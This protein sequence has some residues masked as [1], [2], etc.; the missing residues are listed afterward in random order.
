MSQQAVIQQLFAAATQQFDLGHVSQAKQL[1]IQLLDQDAG[2]APTLC[3]HGM[4]ARK[5]GHSPLAVELI[6][7]ALEKEPANP[8]YWNHLGLAMQ[9]LGYMQEAIQLYRQ[10]LAFDAHHLELLTQLAKALCITGRV[11]EATACFQQAILAVRDNPGLLVNYGN[12]LMSQGQ[13]EEAV[14]QYWQAVQIDPSFGLAH[15]NLGS[16]AYQLRDYAQARVHFESA[17]RVNPADEQAYF[18]LAYAYKNAGQPLEEFAVYQRWAS[19]RPDSVLAHL[20]LGI[21]HEN[22]QD[23]VGAAAHFIRLGQLQPELMLWSVRLASLSPP[24]AIRTEDINRNRQQLCQILA[25]DIPLKSGFDLQM[26]FDSRC[27]PPSNLAYHGCDDQPLKSQFADWLVASLGIEVRKQSAQPVVNRKIKIGFLVTENHERV[28]KRVLGGYLQH[29]NWERFALEIIC[30]ISR[31]TGIKAL[32]PELEDMSYLGLPT[33]IVQ[34]VSTLHQA[35]LDVLFF[36]EVGTDV[37]NY[38][39]SLYRFAPVQ[40]TSWGYPTTSGSPNMDYYISSAL[41]EPENAQ[42]HYREKLL[43]MDSLP[44]YFESPKLPTVFKT[45]AELGLSDEMRLYVCPQT[46]LKFHPDFDEI[47]AGILVQDPLGWIILPEGLY[48]IWTEQLQRRFQATIPAVDRIR[49]LPQLAYEDYLSLLHHSD[50]LLDPLYFGG[51]L[52]TYEM[53]ALGKPIVTLPGESMRGRFTLGC[54]RKMGVMDCVVESR[55]AYI[56]LAVKLATDVDYRHSVQTKISAA[57]SVLFDDMSAVREMEQLLIQ[58]VD[59]AVV[60]AA[61]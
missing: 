42:R 2:H 11:R 55:R 33:S 35:D 15:F 32:F 41:L 30:P 34:C 48:P 8:N 18:Y 4:I 26:A 5:M 40:C 24:I 47:L 31:V 19:H 22:R 1:C 61:H 58:A 60:Q 14:G 37:K 23:M 38:L 44:S 49:F 39:L 50:V 54:Y 56:A 7:K 36:F 51:G 53:L 29:F 25:E 27:Q 13:A 57:S 59:S 28:F 52:T 9:D 10:G 17:I 20:R 3:L 12:F 43:L 46:L 45:R 16:A 21:W 6:S